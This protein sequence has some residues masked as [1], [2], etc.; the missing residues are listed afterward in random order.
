MAKTKNRSW[1]IYLFGALGGLLFGYDTGIISGAILFI[2]DDLHLNS[3]T[4]GL[5]VSSI[6]VGAMIGSAM[7]GVLS[8][9]Y[10]RRRIIIIS[11]VIFCIGA[12]GSAFSVSTGLLVLF[13]IVL[14]IGVGNASTLVPMYLSEMAPSEHRGAL[15]G[16]NQ[17][18]IVTG[19]LIA[20]IV[21]FG[22]QNVHSGWRWMLGLAFVPAF[23]LFVGMI[24]MPES[25]R[26]LIKK[27]LE[28]RGRS[29]LKTLR[30]DTDIDTEINEI[31]LANNQNEGK[32]K[33]LFSKWARPSLM[34]GAGLAFFQQLIGCNTV[35]YYAPTT[36]ANAGFGKSAAIFSSIIIG[37]IDVLVTLVAIFLIDKAGRKRLLLVGNVGMSVS[38][39][40]FWII[41]RFSGTSPAT[42]VLMV[43]ALGSYILFFGISW[44]PVV[45]VMLGEIFPLNVRGIGVGISSVINWLSNLVVS[46]TFPSLL[47]QFG[48]FLFVIYA[49]I[50]V[51]AFLFVKNVVIE[52]SHKSLEQIERELHKQ[53]SLKE[54]MVQ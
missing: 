12:I 35:I 41:S 22:F 31:K 5:V 48:N 44:G 14:G 11:A 21:N 43:V 50:G 37:A 51:A 52:T 24:F 53:G 54:S 30:G 45:W 39:V 33:D 42:A 38:L 17:L 9:K 16:L 49:I 36:I 34:I 18:M 8:D 1:I 40:F 29:V 6:L 26:W 13:R 20:Y 25:P 27:G 23:L 2:K 15:S 28:E 4:E 10:G 7:S 19:I 47:Q 3:L 32:L 46:L